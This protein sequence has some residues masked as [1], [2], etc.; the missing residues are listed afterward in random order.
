MHSTTWSEFDKIGEDSEK[1]STLAITSALS[2][3][4]K[5]DPV[6]QMK[7]VRED[8]II[9]KADNLYFLYPFWFMQVEVHALSC[10]ECFRIHHF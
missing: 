5:L 10:A 1:T 2:G 7:T 8:N 3:L 4:L 6:D 9:L